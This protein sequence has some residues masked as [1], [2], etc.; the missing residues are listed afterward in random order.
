MLIVM[1]GPPASGKSTIAA[2]V[3]RR[4][5]CALVSVDPIEAAMWTAGVS[6]DQPTGL[7]AYVV[8]EAVAR[9]QLRLGHDVI[10]DA[11]ND[12]E[13]AR[14]QWRDLARVAAV[15]VLFVEVVADDAEEHRRRLVERRRDI[16]G[17]PEP[18]WESVRAR[19]RALSA[20]DEDRIRLDFLSAPEVN[21]DEIVAAVA[22]RRE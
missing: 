5:G 11:V 9:E 20:W 3:S 21:A 1:A 8:A 10:I 6:R 4:L 17:F 18:D 14:Q 2:L 7:A 16:E 12:V 22:R 13:A 15:D 19:V